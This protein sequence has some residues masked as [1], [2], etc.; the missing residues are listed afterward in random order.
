MSKQTIAI[1]LGA[2]VLFAV[3]VGASLGLI[4]DEESPANTPAATVPIGSVET[5]AHTM[6]GGGTMTGPMEE[7][8]AGTGTLPGTEDMPGTMTEP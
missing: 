7:D 2:V 6:P 8:E 5:G 3:S 1:V 4:G